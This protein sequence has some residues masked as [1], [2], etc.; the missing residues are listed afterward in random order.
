MPGGNAKHPKI[1]Q[2]LAIAP[3]M[4]RKKTYGN[5]PAPEAIMDTAV[6]GSMV[7][8][9]TASRIE[10]RAFAAVATSNVAK[11]MINTFWIQLNQINAGESRP[12][13]EPTEHKKWVYLVQG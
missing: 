6:K 5:Y 9:E 12:D 10:S 13:V 7:D 8:F 2:M 1:V 11:N 4:L 3:A